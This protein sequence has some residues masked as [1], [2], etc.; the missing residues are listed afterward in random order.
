MIAIMRQRLSRLRQPARA[1]RIAVWL[2]VVWAVVVWNVVFDR[3]LVVAGR[4]YINAAA[5]AD[6]TGGPYARIDDWMRPAVTEGLW[7]ASAAAL[8]ILVVG[9]VAVRFARRRSAMGS[10][11]DWSGSST[12]VTAP[13]S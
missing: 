5:I 4:Q 2:W 11:A 7:V 8:A 10:Q 3:V 6:S 9:F 12:S 13:G 1:A